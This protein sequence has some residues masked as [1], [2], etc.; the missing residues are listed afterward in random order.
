MKLPRRNFL[1]LAAGAAALPAA[2]RFARAQAYPMRPVRLIAPFAPAGPG[3]ITAR[4]MG[5]WLSERLG[6]PFVIDNRPG[7]AGN[8]GTEVVVRAPADGYTLL[9]VGS[10]SAINA[11]LY[12][13]LNFNFIRDIAPVASIY[14]GPAVLVVHPSVPAKSVPEFIAYAKANPRKLNMASG[15]T[16]TGTHIAGELFKM[17]AG[18][19]LVHVPYRGGGPALTDLL[20]GQMQVYFPTTV[21]SIGYIRA[22]RLRAL[23]VTAAT[24]SDAL[25]DI[26][27]VGEFVPGYEASF[28]S[29]IGAPKATPADRRETKQGDQR[30]PRR[31]QAK[32]APCRP[33][34]RRARA[35]ARRFWQADCRRNR[36]MAQG[37]PGGQHQGGMKRRVVQRGTP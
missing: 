2:S 25:P 26:P 21:A 10:W 30:G 31:S 32:G 14:R 8:I 22:G 23:A 34:W 11:T 36:E 17:M 12:D 20:G 33:R 35:L 15:G 28:W 37:D 19:D 13:K 3:D 16:G 18:V 6:Q 5:Q 9:M 4:L 27:T 1:H 24:R 29:G 7:A